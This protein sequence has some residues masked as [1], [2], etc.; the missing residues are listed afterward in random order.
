MKKYF[1][2]VAAIPLTLL[3][4]A[5]A[6]DIL[7]KLGIEKSQADYAIRNNVFHLNS[8]QLPYAKLLS[9]VIKGDKVGA[10]KELCAYIKNYSE[11]KEFADEYAKYRNSM[12]P[13]SEPQQMPAEVIKQMKENLELYEKMA[14]EMP[15]QK[16]AYATMI[17]EMKKSIAESEDPHPNQTKWQKEYPADPKI[18]VKKA[19]QKYLD[20]EATVDFNAQLTSA[21]KYGKRRFVNTEYERKSSEWKAIYRAGKDVNNEVAVFVKQWLQQ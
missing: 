14:K 7:Q 16:E 21:D 17:A 3:S 19:L 10:A 9:E 4:F 18:L 6:N 15:A 2:I 5:I 13:T 11:S 12:K 1:I 8:F 20:V